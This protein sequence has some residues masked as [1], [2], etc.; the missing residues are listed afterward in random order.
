MKYQYEQF[1]ELSR[2]LCNFMSGLYARCINKYPS[3]YSSI[4]K[5]NYFQRFRDYMDNWSQLGF[6]T[7]GLFKELLTFDQI[8]RNAII[9]KCTEH[10]DINI[11]N[12]WCDYYKTLCCKI[13]DKY[14]N[15]SF[16]LYLSLY[17]ALY[18]TAHTFGIQASNVYALESVVCFMMKTH[19]RR[20]YYFINE[21]TNK[22]ISEGPDKPYT[23]M[24]RTYRIAA[25]KALIGKSGL[26]KNIDKTRIAEFVEAVTGGNIET[27]GKDTVSYKKPTADAIAG[28]AEL[29]KKIGI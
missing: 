25:L 27:K 2:G 12:Q 11:I 4:S 7:D 16:Y 19:S 15:R 28:A 3:P 20:Q 1:I 13:G 9:V 14:I 22:V 29:L 21:T 18:D 23:T 8:A 24:P 26:C 17:Q 5:E 6:Y 10:L